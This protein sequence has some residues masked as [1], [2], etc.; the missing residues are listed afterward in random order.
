V[1]ADLRSRTSKLAILALGLAWGSVAAQKSTPVETDENSAA[2]VRLEA[3]DGQTDFKIG[4]PVILDLV[5]NSRSQAYV[6]DTDTSPYLPVPDLVELAPQ[7]GWVRSH[8]S[9]RGKSQNAA[10]LANLGSSS[11]RVPVLLN[12]TITFQEPGH[13]D[14]TLTTERL[15][16]SDKWW[17]STPLES[18]DACRTTN[19]VGIDLSARDE[20][21]E[22]AL[23]VSLSRKLEETKSK[24]SASELTPEQKEELSQE[25][26]SQMRTADASESSRRQTEALLRKLNDMVSN[27]LAAIQKQED[28]RR[29]AAV[30][31]AYLAGDNA[32]RAKVHF[33]ADEREVGKAN[34]IGP[35]MRDGLPSS[36]NK[37][38]QVTLLEAA[39]RD[40][41]RVPT[42]EL[43]SALRQAKEL[44]HK[45]MVT[46]EATLWAG[47][48]EERKAALDKYQAEIYEIIATLPLRSESNRAETIDYL[49]RL[50]V[51]NQFN[52]RQTTNAKPN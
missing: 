26:D 49:K 11:I 27:Q 37:H 31:L 38:L 39:W 20:S 13:Y 51:P 12:R 10:E 19:A 50:G 8:S 14:V 25:I 6:V 28:L 30:R 47:T 33:I 44:M 43:H 9:F 17:L 52:R 29:D 15:K 1:G 36:R 4:D 35:I 32:M 34:P 45:Q 24:P 7:G 46:D 41:F 40:P 16:A 2:T 3:H 21:E 42:S 5:F 22:A 23:V 48:D 18:C